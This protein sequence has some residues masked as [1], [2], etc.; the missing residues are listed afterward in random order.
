M[1]QV[2]KHKE[3]FIVLKND[4]TFTYDKTWYPTSQECIKMQGTGTW[5]KNGSEIVLEG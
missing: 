2:A 1:S 3:G 5:S 4:N